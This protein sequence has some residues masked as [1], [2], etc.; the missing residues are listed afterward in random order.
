M[1][2]YKLFANENKREPNLSSSNDFE[3]RL[4][5]ALAYLREQKEKIIQIK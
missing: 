4:A 1:A 3:R 2:L 5:V